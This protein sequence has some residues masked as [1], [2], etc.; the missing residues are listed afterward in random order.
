MS[1]TGQSMRGLLVFIT[2]IRNCK[3]KDQEQERVKK[4]IAKIRGKFN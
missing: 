3:S 4:E 1:I 2:E